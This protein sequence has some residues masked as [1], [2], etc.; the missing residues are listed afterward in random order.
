MPLASP[1]ASPRSS[2]HKIWKFPQEDPSFSWRTGHYKLAAEGIMHA[3]IPPAPANAHSNLRRGQ[4]VYLLPL[5]YKQE[6]ILEG[7]STGHITEAEFHV[8]LADHPG[9]LLV[10]GMDMH[11]QRPIQSRLWFL[12]Q[13][14]EIVLK[15]YLSFSIDQTGSQ[16]TSSEYITLRGLH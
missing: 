16:I 12:S 15:K 13:G 7:V 10:G 5:L 3:H 1:W 9:C 2:R 6:T 8:T 4:T 14:K 11:L